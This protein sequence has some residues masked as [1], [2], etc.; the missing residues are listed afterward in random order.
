MA[1]ELAKA[2]VQIL[3]SAEGIKGKLAGIMDGEAASAGKSSGSAFGASFSDTFSGVLS[4]AGK[5]A[6]A[7]IGATTAAVG[8]ATA[9]VGALTKASVDSYAEYEQLLGGVQKLYGNMGMSLEDYAKS[10]GKSSEEV[11]DKWESLGRAQEQVLKN[12]QNAYKTAGMST[13]EYMETATSF[14]ASLINSLGGDTEK[15]AEMTDVAMRAISDN[16]NTFGGD[17]E[18]VTNAYKGFSKGTFTML[19]NLKLGYGGTKEEMERLIADANEYA[20]SIG[21]TGDLTLNSFADI[22]TAI[23]LVQQKQQIAGTTAR[24]ATTTISGSLGMLKASWANLL[25]GFSDSEADLDTLFNNLV[26]TITGSTD[27]AGNHINGVL[28]N[29]IPVATQAISS[30]TTLIEKA[31]PQIAAIIPPLVSDL[32]P[33]LI[34]AGA[35]IVGALGSAIMDNLP[36]ILWSLGD[37]MQ[38]ILQSLVESS[39]NSDG[40]V[41]EIINMIL[42]VFEENY[43]QFMDMGA[44]IILNVLTGMVDHI[45]DTIYYITEIINHIGEMLI[46][47]APLLI[48]VGADLLLQLA[49]GLANALPVLLPTLVQ[50]ITSIIQ[51]FIDN[52]DKFTEIAVTIMNTIANAIP[53]VLPVLI[54]A[55]PPLFTSLAEAIISN[56]PT[57]LAAQVQMIGLLAAGIVENL[58]VFLS[59]IVQI[60]TGIIGVIMEKT[61]DIRAKIA[62]TA[63]NVVTTIQTFLSPYNLGFIVGQAIAS[64]GTAFENLIPKTKEVFE[65]ALDKVKDFGKRLKSEGP[66]MAKTFVKDFLNSFKELGSGLYKAGLEAIDSLW[67][68]I[69]EK[70]G[71][72][73]DQ[74]KGMVSSLTQ[75]IK[76]GFNGAGSS[77][78]STA[79]T[80]AKAVGSTSA[81]SAT[82]LRATSVTNETSNTFN[83]TITVNGAEDPEAWTRGF[84]RTLNR[85]AIMANG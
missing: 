71:W 35:G 2:Y 34:T 32:V 74:V 55:L 65:K 26:E 66:E 78:S 49:D 56:F 31:G 36:S 60:F 20:V 42:G 6:T 63:S 5:L 29:V 53:T 8:A 12:A 85:Q 7:A 11:K 70:W 9:G 33:Q 50:V 62:E 23:D 40:T 51:G 77:N 13:N 48:S 82:A 38:S 21:E 37:A 16:W 58:P 68:G 84:V 72:L 83:N 44:E 43:M 18:G 14:S 4:G 64:I 59:A 76:D 25:T 47:Y 41:L 81:R 17:L 27:E 28:D 45:G 69:S 79:S 61:A 3:P 80:T 1:T 67:K 22:V 46:E 57:L 30:V 19:D 10:Q 73:K 54:Q 75:G 52:M 24:E 39:S 15:A